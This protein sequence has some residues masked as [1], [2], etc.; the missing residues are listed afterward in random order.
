MR[1]LLLAAACA[2]TLA[3]CAAPAPAT[4]KDLL[5]VATTPIARDLVDTLVAGVPGA[6]VVSLVPPGAD[7]HEYAPTPA[8]AR[9]LAVARALIVVGA[10]Y[11]DEWL[12]R[13]L[14]NAGGSR[15]VITA[16]EGVDLLPLGTAGAGALD[17]DPHV[18]LDP[19][20]WQ[21]AT[22]TV[23]RGLAALEPAL[24]P[25]I[26]ANAAAY[27]AKLKALDAETASA[28]AAIPPDQRVLV[29]T[30]DALGYYAARY[31]FSIAGVVLPGGGSE[32][33]P[34]AQDLRKLVDAIRARKAK[35]IFTEAGL[36]RRITETVA[37]ETGIAIVDN[38][39]V[40]TLSPPGGPAPTLIDL[41]RHNT[42]TIVAALK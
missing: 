31:G 8:D 38:L 18:W 22:V 1:K 14:Q 29:T 15:P 17:G 39:Y 7:P 12:G 32:V 40:D 24:T 2:A 5:F 41:I 26:D 13:F 28:V 25:T 36:D 20:R 27:V 34:S 10:R 33:A 11:E 19:M 9:A 6:R 23:A 42:A 3:A 4:P 35:A 21:Q 16:A 30:H 37:R